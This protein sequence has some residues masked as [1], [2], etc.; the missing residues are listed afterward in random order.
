VRDDEVGLAERAIVGSLRVRH[1]EKNVGEPGQARAALRLDESARVGVD[2]QHA[3]GPRGEVAGK[4]AGSGPD[5]EHGTTVK[6]FHGEPRD[7]GRRQG[8]VSPA[9]R[10]RTLARRLHVPSHSSVSDPSILRSERAP[11]ARRRRRTAP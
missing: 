6:R 9:V 1:H 2:P 5:V 10:R 8:A 11:D 7:Q 4:A 3:P